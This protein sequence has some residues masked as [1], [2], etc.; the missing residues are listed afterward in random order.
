MTTQHPGLGSTL[1]TRP[2]L[3]FRVR[4]WQDG[5]SWEEFHRL[6]HRLI[7][8]RARRAGLGHADA[9]DVT[10]EVLKRVA[11][12]IREFEFDAKRGSFRG[13]LMH[14]T[15]WRIGDKF[16]SK[17]RQPAVGAVSPPSDG[18]ARGTAEIERVPAPVAD[19]DEWDR[20]WRQH[21]L[22][23]A[24]ERLA[25]QVKAQHF[26]VFELYV[27][28]GWPVMKV[29]SK[30]GINPASVYVIGHRLTKL[31]KVEV[32]KLQQQVG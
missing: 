6:Y 23:M 9:Q 7:Y 5:A 27:R 12:S 30:L 26:Q 29:S 13:W 15:Q 8:G 2:T 4:D 31:L 17:A 11:E 28:Q 21:V 22:A 32:E 1:L 18:T 20:E 3:L 25:R 19:E 10:Q 24:L 14:Q 16:E